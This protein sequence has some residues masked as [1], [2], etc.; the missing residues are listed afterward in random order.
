MT[1]LL[2]SAPLCPY[3]QLSS[4]FTCGPEI[5]IVPHTMLG[6]GSPCAFGRRGMGLWSHT[7]RLTCAESQ[8]TV[9]AVAQASPRSQAHP[10]EGWLAMGELAQDVAHASPLPP[11]KLRR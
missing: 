2:L 8:A 3:I 9:P 1:R 10:G 7:E 11:V 6:A 4:R 5:W